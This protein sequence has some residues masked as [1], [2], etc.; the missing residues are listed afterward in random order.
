M[1]LPHSLEAEQGVL[2]CIQMDPKHCAPILA[3]RGV[4]G[5]WFYDGRNEEL[6]LLFGQMIAAGLPLDAVTLSPRVAELQNAKIDLSYVLAMSDAVP[7]AHNLDYY[8]EDLESVYVRRRTILQANH[9]ISVASKSDCNTETLTAEA[10]GIVR[11]IRCERADSLPEIVDAAAFMRSELPD[12]PEAIGGILHQGSKLVVSGAS[13]AGKTWLFI[14]LAVSVSTGTP[15]L[16]IPTSQGRVLYL[17]TELTP[18][19]FQ[20]RLRYVCNAAG[21]STDS[22]NLDL[23]HLRGRTSPWNIIIPKIRSRVK[24][25]GYILIIVDPLYRLYGALKENSAEDMGI[26]TNALGELAEESGAAIA[27]ATHHSKGNQSSKDSI[28][29][30]SGSGVIA[31]DADALID[32]SANEVADAYS[33]SLRLRDF[34]PVPEFGVRWEFPLFRRDENIDPS[35][36]KLAAGRPR[37]VNPSELLKAISD[38]TAE[39]PVSI[40]EWA[41]I[42][43]NK[44][45]TLSEYL[46][47]FRRKGL[48]QTI[49]EGSKARQFLTAKGQEFMN[50]NEGAQ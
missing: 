44:R 43:G 48:I 36:L 29:R 41:A 46:P 32:F 7:S 45:Q 20:K 22:L 10:E 30:I 50:L 49:G 3:K 25:S 35:K 1:T 13:K 21:V 27:I 33:V 23:W 6:F 11:T 47:E 2:G 34:K 5:A 26:L 38:R 4:T 42:S 9:L 31:R 37:R 19:T 18:R 8:L 39:N 14:D 17:N 16:G 40:S 12:A 24:N 28:D 15:W